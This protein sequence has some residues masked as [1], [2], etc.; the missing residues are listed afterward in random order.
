[1]TF[2]H[3]LFGSSP[4][5]DLQMLRLLINDLLKLSYLQFMVKVG[6]RV[7]FG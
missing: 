1:M 4:I 5:G 2:G 6:V 3:T 7:E